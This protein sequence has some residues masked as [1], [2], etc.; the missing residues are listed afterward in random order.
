MATMKDIAAALNVSE[1]TV[2]RALSG[3]SRL[4]VEMRN[5]VIKTA[6]DMNYFS[7]KPQSVIPVK[8]STIGMI[9]SEIN[10]NY[11][12]EIVGAVER[13]LRSAGYS[14]LLGLTSFDERNK[15]NLLRTFAQKKVEG[16]I[17]E[18][19]CRNS[20][21]LDELRLARH[22]YKAPVV[23]FKSVEDSRNEFDSI[24]L[25]ERTGVI[26]LAEHLISLGHK[27][28]AFIGDIKS[29]TRCDYFLRTLRSKGIELRHECVRLGEERFEK[30]GYLRMNEI[31]QLSKR[32]TAVVATYD[33]V[34]LGAQRAILEAG[35]S[36]PGDI[37]VAGIDNDR[38][39]PYY[40][41]SITSVNRISDDMGD[42]AV[43]LLLNRINDKNLN[44]VQ[45]VIVRAQLVVR[46]STGPAPTIITSSNPI[47]A[48]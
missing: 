15:I 46:E 9:I 28:I 43:T 8:T 33:A 4:S 26:Q 47:D 13:K 32:P 11:Y 7:N 25:D 39:T 5:K 40:T 18:T 30:S 16:I 37:S 31:L 14:M 17:C 27:D 34:A 23:I 24:T 19:T 22:K 45:E 48:K 20:E 1:S 6:Q 3:S 21:V 36:I 29:S 35:L 42:M 41:P 12:I 10:S 2:S 44:V 38:E